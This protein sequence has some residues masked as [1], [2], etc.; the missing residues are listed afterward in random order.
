M[1][2][3]VFVSGKRLQP[4]LMFVGQEAYSK[5]GALEGASLG[6]ALAFFAN[7][8]GARDKHSYLL[9]KSIQFVSFFSNNNDCWRV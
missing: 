5:S 7:F 1:F 3:R 9:T 2:I 6:W 4:S 8:K